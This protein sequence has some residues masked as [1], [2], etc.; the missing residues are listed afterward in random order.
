[1]QVLHLL[2]VTN[3]SCNAVENGLGVQ[4]VLIIPFLNI[5][6]H[7]CHIL[8]NIYIFVNKTEYVNFCIEKEFWI[9]CCKSFSGTSG[10]SDHLEFLKFRRHVYIGI[11]P[12]SLTKQN[13][14]Q[15]E[16]WLDHF[17]PNLPIFLSIF[18][19]SGFSLS[20]TM[21]MST[22]NIFRVL[23]SYDIKAIDHLLL[24]LW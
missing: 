6:N 2:A 5:I 1:L 20:L 18:Y 9:L 11:G 22:T 14:K 19:W 10:S 21:S 12:V 23:H 17:V 15:C 7:W 16:S 13:K 24:V 4:N 8:T 3:S